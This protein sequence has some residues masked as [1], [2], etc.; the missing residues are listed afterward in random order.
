MTLI[1]DSY[2]LCRVFKKATI[3]PKSIGEKANGVDVE[4][5]VWQM[6]DEQDM[7]VDDGGAPES[8]RGGIESNEDGDSFDHFLY[9]YNPKIFS[10]EN[11][12][13]DLT[14]GNVADD[15]PAPV[16]SDNEANSSAN[17]LYPIHIDCPSN[18]MQVL[19]LNSHQLYS[20]YNTIKFNH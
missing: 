16:A 13:S 9:E 1:Q 6:A 8:S 7:Q 17:N 20:S 3:V 11:S 14:Q 15:L 4:A 18:F 5:P 12:S 10:S 2:A 19:L